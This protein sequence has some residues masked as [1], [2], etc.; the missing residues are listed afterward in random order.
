MTDAEFNELLAGLVERIAMIDWHAGAMRPPNE[1]RARET[2]N[3]VRNVFTGL[4]ATA[5][6]LRS[7]GDQEGGISSEGI[8]RSILQWFVRYPYNELT[9]EEAQE[10]TRQVFAI[11]SAVESLDVSPDAQ[12][13]VHNPLPGGDATRDPGARRRPRTTPARRE[14][15]AM[16]IGGGLAF[17]GFLGLAAYAASRS[18][19]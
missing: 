10:A 1:R 16:S 5:R 14:D 9:Y 4:L 7:Q 12:A 2:S 19:A 18:R 3:A 8:A 13:S 6:N 11:V 17:L 15:G